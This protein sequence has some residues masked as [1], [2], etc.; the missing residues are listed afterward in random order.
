MGATT[1]VGFATIISGDTF[2]RYRIYLDGLNEWG[3]GTA[4][5]DTNLYRGGANLL[6]TDD[7]FRAANF[8]D[9]GWTSYTPTWTTQTGSNTPS[10]GNAVVDCKW[11]KFGRMVVVRFSI[12]FGS[13]TNFGAAP[14]GSD[15]WQF[16]IPVTAAGTTDEGLGFMEMYQSATANG[17]ARVKLYSNSGIRL[18]V[19]IG[20]TANIGADVDSTQP[21]TWASGNTLRGT[22][23][24]ESAS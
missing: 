20:S 2:D 19:S 22:F 7:T 1:S 6:V 12:T 21:F 14:T 9:L 18:G 8:N 13:T 17:L 23:I 3:P 5:R 11:N 16:S 4:A 15:N 24:Y 10:F